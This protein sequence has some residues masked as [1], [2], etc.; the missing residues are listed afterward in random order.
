MSFYLFERQWE[1]DSER[2]RQRLTPQMTRSWKLNPGPHSNGR[3]PAAEVI[4]YS[5]PERAPAGSWLWEQS[6]EPNPDTP[7]WDDT[8]IQ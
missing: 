5:L 6:Q 3:D 7:P 1:T 2:N 4:A 8:D